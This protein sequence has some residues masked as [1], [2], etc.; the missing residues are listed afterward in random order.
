DEHA[1]V[2]ERLDGSAVRTDAPAGDAG[3]CNVTFPTTYESP[4]F[5]DNAKAEL[6]LQRNFADFVEKMSG[7][8]AAFAA[9]ASAP[10]VSKD[11]LEGKWLAGSPSV[12]SATTAAYQAKVEPWIAAY[13]TALAAG[14]FTPGPSDGG[15]TGGVYGGFVFDPTGLDLHQVMEQGSY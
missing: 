13:A 9:D 10:T 6:A 4:T 14:P 15:G 3:T 8:E 7:V 12:K 11:D 2:R 1:I 5:E